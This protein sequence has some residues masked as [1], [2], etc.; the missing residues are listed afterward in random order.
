MI[1]IHLPRRFSE[2]GTTTPIIVHEPEPIRPH[3]IRNL[4]A[5]G[6]AARPPVFSV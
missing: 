6:K 4:N 5:G 3:L 1:R 2:S